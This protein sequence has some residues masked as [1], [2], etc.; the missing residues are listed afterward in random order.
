MVLVIRKRT[1][2][3]GMITETS[4]L[5]EIN[6]KILGGKFRDNTNFRDLII[7]GAS[8]RVSGRGGPTDGRAGDGG[9]WRIGPLRHRDRR[10]AVEEL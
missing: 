9:Q 2:S 10:A 5:A 8:A 1:T 6:S 4:I 3:P 7:E